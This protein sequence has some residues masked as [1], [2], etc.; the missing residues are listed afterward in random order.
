MS[1][2]VELVELKDAKMEDISIVRP[3][4]DTVADDSAEEAIESTDESSE[5][6]TTDDT[7]EEESSEES[8]EATEEESSEEEVT[9]E[10]TESSESGSTDEASGPSAEQ[11]SEIESQYFSDNFEGFANAEEVNEHITHLTEN[12]ITD[13]KALEF[14]LAMKFQEY[15]DGRSGDMNDI[16][17]QF[18]DTQTQDYDQFDDMDLL[19]ANMERK[20]PNRDPESV[21]IKLNSLYKIGE[22]DEFSA[23]EIRIAK[24]DME[25]DAILARNE[26]KDVQTKTALKEPAKEV[27]AKEDVQK[28][29]DDKAKWTADVKTSLSDFDSLELAVGEKGDNFKYEVKPSDEVRSIMETPASFFQRYETKDSKGVIS[30][31]LNKFRNDITKI[32]EF[33]NII[34]SVSVNGT[35]KAI[36]KRLDEKKNVTNKDTGSSSAKKE[37]SGIRGVGKAF[38]ANKK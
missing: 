12:Q 26:L 5:E 1:D 8:E 9:E 13:E 6:E 2:E 19:R 15:R 16:F 29:E 20:F 34:K 4:D 21:E 25:E 30:I 38:I 27:Q 17:I 7:T 31:D 37:E 23:E 32:I 11:K 28:S 18:L 22:E 36:Q 35:S 3:G 10:E 14:D 33:D 24:M